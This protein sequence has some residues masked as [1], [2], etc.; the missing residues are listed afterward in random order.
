[1]AGKL[2]AKQAR[3]KTQQERDVYA[4]TKIEQ[5]LDSI[6]ITQKKKT[7]DPVR[8]KALEIRYN[9][10]RPALSAVEQTNHEPSRG[11]DEIINDIKALLAS[12]PELLATLLPGYEIV[13]LVSVASITHDAPQQ[14]Q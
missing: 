7:I 10:L 6:G 4:L 14:T 13:P 2:G 11:Q 3:P 1:M 8:L 5:I 12:K 9:K